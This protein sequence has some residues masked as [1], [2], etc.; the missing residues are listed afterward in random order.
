MNIKQKDHRVD[1][2]KVV[3][4]VTVVTGLSVWR[5]VDV[6]DQ[7]LEIGVH[8]PTSWPEDSHACCSTSWPCSSPSSIPCSHLISKYVVANS[9]PTLWPQHNLHCILTYPHPVHD[10][11]P[12][13]MHVSREAWDS[14]LQLF[15]KPQQGNHE[16]WWC[17]CS[18]WSWKEFWWW[19]PT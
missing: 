7:G 2:V 6:K 11:S 9:Q 17:R 18:E 15:V 5:V 8:W 19:W 4:V 13:H 12:P 14:S 16:W 10:F 1:K 3:E